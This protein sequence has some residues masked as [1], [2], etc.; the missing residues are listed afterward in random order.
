MA[1]DLSVGYSTNPEHGP[2]AS[3]APYFVVA[4]ELQAHSDWERHALDANIHGSYTEYAANL[5]PSLNAPYLDSRIN[6]RVD[7]LHN[8]Q[9]VIESR[10][11]IA[12][13]NPG[14]PNL[15]AELAKLPPN[16]D[17][18]GTLGVIQTFNRLSV[19]LKGAFDRNI[20]DNSVLTDGEIS[21]N[22]DR[23][24]DQYAGIVRVG[25]ELNPG[26]KPFVEVQE[27]ERIHDD[28]FD[29]SGLERASVGTT[30]KAGA[31]VDLFGSLT[32]EMAL[33]Y[34]HR[35]YQD[36]TLPDIAGTIANGSLLWQA[37]ALTTAKLTASSQV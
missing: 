6:G 35:A 13:D 17:I 12:T 16:F 22:G 31:A 1:D 9:V 28:Q 26:L 21:S 36:P 3:A 11:L 30:A 15:P 29:R 2:G 34:T 25:Y 7:V 14:S 19:S 18:G 10:L 33:G 37:T 32:G 24:F 23:N 5:V 20:Y 8:T 4:P 27:D